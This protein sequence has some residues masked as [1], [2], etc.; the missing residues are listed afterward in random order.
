MKKRFF[1]LA[2]LSLLTVALPTTFTG[3]KDYDD[4]IDNLENKTD[5]LQKQIDTL[6]GALKGYQTEA[7]TAAQAAKDA[8]AKAQATADK[9][10]KDAQE[11]IALAKAAQ[12][13]AAQAKADAVAEIIKV[14]EGYAT[15][16]DLNAVADRITAVEGTLKTLTGGSDV[17]NLAQTVAT[18]ETQVKAL[19]KYTK[20]LEELNG[21]GNAAEQIKQ[22]TAAI[23]T[24][25]GEI[26]TIKK[27]NSDLSK[28]V[29]GLD[30]QLS[31]LSDLVASVH[32]NLVVIMGTQLRSLVF[33]PEL[34]ADGIESVE[35]EY[36]AYKPWST[37]ADSLT[38]NNE[39]GVTC[40]VISKPE[41]WNFTKQ[42]AE[43]A[44]NPVKTVR[45]HM[46]PSSAVVKADQVSF[47][48]KDVEVISRASVA[49]LTIVNDAF[50]TENGIM[51][52]GF[53]ANG[54][55]IKTGAQNEGS[56]FA[57]NAQIQKKNGQDTTITS[58]Y[59]ML[60]ASQVIPQAIAFNSVVPQ[61]NNCPTPSRNDELYTTVE[62]AIKNAPSLA[63]AYTDAINL[64]ALEIHY[65]WVTKTK[66]KGEH[67]VWKY[68]E[69]KHYGLS[70]EYELIDYTS[71]TN[72]TSESKYCK[73]S[74][75]EN[76]ILTPWGVDKEGEPAYE[77]GI[78]SVGR[79]PIVRVLV[80]CGNDVVLK[81]F[82]KVQIVKEV[83][84]KISNLID[85]GKINFGCNDADKKVS[86]STISDFI[87]QNTAA[88]SK[89]EFNQLYQ[90]SKNAADGTAIQYVYNA[91]NKTFAPA[92]ANNYIGVVTEENNAT[93]TTTDVLKW[94]L[95]TKD[96]QVVYEKPDHKT[97]I[98]VAYVHRTAPTIY[99]TIYIPL[100]VEVVKPA[101]ATVATKVQANW[102]RNQT[103]TIFNV[104]QPMDGQLP[105]PFT[106]NLNEAWATGSASKPSFTGI[107]AGFPSFTA[108][109]FANQGVGLDGGYKYY[110]TAGNNRTLDGV[111]YSVDNAK[112]QG[113][114]SGNAHNVA[115][116]DMG[117]HALLA[118][119]GEYTNTKLYAKVGSNAKEVIATIDQ[120]TGDITYKENTTSKYVLNKYAS[121]GDG[122]DRTNAKLFA[123]IGIC[124]YNACDIAMPLTNGV[125]PN[126]ILRPI[127]VYPVEGK[128]FTDAVANG[129]KLD[130][131]SLL[132]FDDWRG[133]DFVG[134][135]AWL[136][137]Y[138]DVTNVTV[139]LNDMTTD[140]VNGT[141]QKFD[142]VRDAFRVEN[143]AAM[144]WINRTKNNAVN[145]LAK[146][147]RSFGTIVYD[148]RK[149]NKNTFKVRIPVEVTYYWGTITVE[150]EATVNNTLNPGN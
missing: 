116:K 145:I 34:Y 143:N 87:L 74:G 129:S 77:H 4:D 21:L 78:S 108:A 142:A 124:A 137:A 75:D 106:Q 48:S 107:T 98:Y 132:S 53:T 7:T 125:Y 19:E 82:I 117:V 134:E 30:D 133:V 47:I 54:P 92:A 3:C 66:N 22:A 100:Q 67:K 84:Y 61:A 2:L 20:L 136:F 57:A 28:A 85:L 71:G 114:L 121:N 42:G 60:Y 110:F 89:D 90:L 109:T 72:K 50:K 79:Q 24:I 119:N 1:K 118:S 35:Y 18:L 76:S 81:G 147:K 27:N 58:D 130:V 73:L 112:V 55:K 56:I 14:L 102:M 23:T 63:V 95:T 138:Y 52:V 44:Y 68:G 10:E 140:A 146:A 113:L 150:V 46:N 9:A 91:T 148:N 86:W 88:L 25:N 43:K 36:N 97:T 135:D 149:Y 123:E 103:V 38:V 39:Q 40:T 141:F 51:T 105:T 128:A 126:V 131:F 111:T 11:A 104:P 49:A 96:Q 64:N 33:I 8:A 5:D 16:T 122:L 65:N 69:E 93:G 29:S 83:E 17:T 45:Y 15:T 94:V 31:D 12:S 144:T 62:D 139:K 99:A 101:A 32:T 37:T 115:V 59:A 6:S 120:N 70:Y 127:N 26:E 13:A 41:M 80:K